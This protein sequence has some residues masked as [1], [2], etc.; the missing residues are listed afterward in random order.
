VQRFYRA[1]RLLGTIGGWF[2]QELLTLRQTGTGIA[3]GNT[4]F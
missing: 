3:K 1:A 4:A 2:E